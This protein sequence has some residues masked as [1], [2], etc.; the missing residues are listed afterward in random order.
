MSIFY[1]DNRYTF[2]FN[3][4]SPMIRQIFD[5]TF[6]EIWIYP[7]KKIEIPF[8]SSF[9]IFCYGWNVLGIETNENLSVLNLLSMENEK[10]P[11][12]QIMLS[13]VCWAVIVENEGDYIFDN[14]IFKNLTCICFYILSSKT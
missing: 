14:T 3:N 12:I 7:R 4:C 1:D 10:D 5:P 2:I 8:S 6:K 13:C 11:L 9:W